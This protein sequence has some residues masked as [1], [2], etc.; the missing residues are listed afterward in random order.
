LEL[1]KIQTRLLQLEIK[2]RANMVVT[3]FHGDHAHLACVFT[4][5][6]EQIAARAIVNVTAR[7][8]EEEIYLALKQDLGGLKSVQA[9][10]DCYAPG[11]IAAAVYAGHEYA[12]G[13]DGPVPGEVPFRRQLPDCIAG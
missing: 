8:P 9:I 4:G 1:K 7:L 13:L 6:A 2:I 10:G 12:R 3:G 5:R 11:T